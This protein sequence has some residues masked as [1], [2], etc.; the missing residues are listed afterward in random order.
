MLETIN[1]LIVE[2]MDYIFGWILFL[3][4]DAELFTVAVMTSAMLTFVRKWVTDQEWLGRAD[5]D[6]QRLA[7]LIKE[8]KSAKDKDAVKRHKDIIT[9]IKVKSMRFEGKPLLWAIIPVALL[10]TW[11]FSRLAYVP[12]RIGETVELRAFLPRSAVGQLAHL[13][14]ED[15]VEAVGG[16]VQPVV[17]DKPVVAESL[18]DKCNQRLSAFMNMTPP[19]EGVAV[20]RLVGKDT[21]P[22][23]LKLR[24]AGKTYEKGF[25]AGTRHY[26]TPVDVYPDTPVQAI[27]LAMKPLKLFGVVGAI[28]VLFLAPW[29]VAYLLIAIPFVSILKR[30]F[31]IY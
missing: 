27:E 30:V 11:A 5:A 17:D 23:R 25:E 20:W 24:H 15:G 8:D 7:Q 6:Q 14:P 31:K 12:P 22:H 3:P 13:A 16:W 19:L 9:L 18:W 10:A 26:A 2:A 4:R 29:L 21:K 28:D 1:N